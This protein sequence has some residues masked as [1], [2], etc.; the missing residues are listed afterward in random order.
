VT[1]GLPPSPESAAAVQPITAWDLSRGD[2][3]TGF[4]VTLLFSAPHQFPIF[5]SGIIQKNFF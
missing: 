3:D 4:K 5:N 2:F 1:N